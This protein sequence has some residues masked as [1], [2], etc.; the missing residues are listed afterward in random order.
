LDGIHGEDIQYLLRKS[1]IKPQ[2]Y[3]GD[4]SQALDIVRKNHHKVKDT[5]VAKHIA[6][7]LKENN[8]TFLASNVAGHILER[9]AM[10]PNAYALLQNLGGVLYRAHHEKLNAPGASS[11]HKGE[12]EYYTVPR[13][14]LS[15]LVRHKICVLPHAYKAEHLADDAPEWVGG[16]A[17]VL[18]ERRVAEIGM[19][20]RALLSEEDLPEEHGLGMEG[21]D[22][23]AV[24][25]HN[26]LVQEV[27]LF[28][29]KETESGSR[30]ESAGFVKG[31]SS[32][33]VIAQKGDKIEAVASDGQKRGTYAIDVEAGGSI[34]FTIP[35]ST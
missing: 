29:E 9:K 33:V 16:L 20:L 32:I 11:G 15:Y 5:H 13:V 7:V 30:S 1:K 8:I 28:R 31:D 22:E 27:H 14:V 12:G 34:D 24:V 26:L 10:A 23:V 35:A 25:F 6:T 4:V 18:T 17:K 2:L 3:R 21:E 19:A